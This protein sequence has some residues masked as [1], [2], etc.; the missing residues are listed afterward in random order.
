MGKELSFLGLLMSLV[1]IENVEALEL[2]DTSA[3][4][5][6]YAGSAYHLGSRNRNEDNN[7]WGVRYKQLEAFTLVNSF[8][9]RSYILAYHKKWEW[10]KWADIG[11]R[12][13]G[14]TGYTKEENNIQL[15]GITPVISPTINF[16]YKEF[17]FE[18][19]MQ[20]N[21]LIFSLNYSF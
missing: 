6:T 14:I 3:I 13:G 11:L 7:I 16:H 15:L 21:V 8:E 12:V 10:T 4:A 2:A 1:L 18:T 20:T 17:G 19:S 5:I 9:H